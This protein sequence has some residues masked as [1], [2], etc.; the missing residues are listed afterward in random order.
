[1][2]INSGIRHTPPISAISL[3]IPA[4]GL[5]L[6]ALL[7]QFLRHSGIIFLRYRIMTGH[8]GQTHT[9]INHSSKKYAKKHDTDFSFHIPAPP[10]SWLHLL[11]DRNTA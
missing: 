4:A 11:G 7:N 10:I 1:M 9:G 8:T 5:R 6:Y 3:E 2:G